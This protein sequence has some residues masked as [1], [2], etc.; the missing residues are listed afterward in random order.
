MTKNK[1]ALQP[2]LNLICKDSKDMAGGRSNMGWMEPGFQSK[3]QQGHID[4][5]F[6]GY[7]QTTDMEQ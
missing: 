1:A 2:D 5:F 7:D 3:S 4:Q 6:S